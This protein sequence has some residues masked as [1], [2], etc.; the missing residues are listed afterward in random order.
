MLFVD[1]DVLQ[2]SRNSHRRCSVKKKRYLKNFSNLTGKRLRWNLFL[3]KHFIKKRLQHRCFPVKF[4]NI[5][6]TPILKNIYQRLPLKLPNTTSQYRLDW[7]IDGF[8]TLPLSLN[9]GIL[10]F[11]T[12]FAYNSLK[13]SQISWSLDIVRYLFTDVILLSSLMSSNKKVSNCAKTGYC[14]LWCF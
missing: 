8:C 6:R 2:A 10:K 3:T 13:M 5:F 9:S 1:L 7:I 14:Y 11:K 12:K 4:D